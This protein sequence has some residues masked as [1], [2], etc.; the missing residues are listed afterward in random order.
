MIANLFYTNT[1]PLK[2][3]IPIIEATTTTPLFLTE[4][5]LL[6]VGDAGLVAVTVVCEVAGVSTAVAQSLGTSG[7]VKHNADPFSPTTPH[8][9]QC[10]VPNNDFRFL[11][12]LVWSRRKKR[13]WQQWFV[14][15]LFEL[16]G[17]RYDPH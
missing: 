15:S 16:I 17:E 1:L 2:I 10:Q 14:L 8:W 3:T 13:R 11:D 7:L 5:L 6:L 4:P 9:T 12:W